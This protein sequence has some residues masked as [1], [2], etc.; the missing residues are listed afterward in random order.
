V[1]ALV[2]VVL[3]LL[4]GMGRVA[5]ADESPNENL[6]AIRG[7]RVLVEDMPKDAAEEHITRDMLSDQIL[8]TL[9]SK[10]PR[11]QIQ[12]GSAHRFPT[13]YMLLELVV[14]ATIYAGHLSLEVS[15]PAE[16]LIGYDND[17]CNQTFFIGPPAD[18]TAPETCRRVF[19]PVTVWTDRYTLVGPRGEAAAHVER[20]LGQ[21]LEHF[22]AEYDRANP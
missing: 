12:P 1:R 16:L 8:A 20:L 21:L 14:N 6:Q 22:L 11:L 18:Q 10:A 3:G 15:R 2:V 19:S 9:R 13:L 5:S 4:L 17:T 7:I